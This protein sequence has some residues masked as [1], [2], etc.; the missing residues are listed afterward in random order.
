MNIVLGRSG[1][2]VALLA[3]VVGAVSLGWGLW[4]K[5]KEVLRSARIYA[6]LGLGG[7]LLAVAAMEHALF[8]H[9]FSVAYVADN[10]SVQT[11]LLYDFTGLWSALQGSLL[12][13][14]TMLSGYAMAMIAWLRSRL[15]DP[16]GAWAS[17][18]MFALSG[19]FFF[20]LATQ[21]N[22]FVHLTHPPAN[23]AGPDPLLQDRA[24]VAVHPPL[25][26]LGFVGFSV[27]FALVAGSLITGRSADPLYRSARTWAMAALL[28]L[29]A[30]IVAGEWWAYQVL[31]WGGFWGWDPVE[32]AALLPWLVGCAYV[33]SSLAQERRGLLRVW[34]ISLLA[35]AFCLT[36]LAT[37]LTRSGVLVSVHAFSN[38]NLGGFLIGAFL[39]VAVGSAVLVAWRSDLLASSL[40]IETLASK[41]G[42]FLLNNLAFGAAAAIVLLGTL[43]PLFY[44]AVFGQQI[45]VGAPY[46]DSTLEPVGVVLLFLMAA[47][48]AFGWRDSSLA[49]VLGRLRWP[50]WA[51]AATVVGLVVAGVRPWMAVAAFGLGAF[52]GVSA[53]RGL[54][55]ALRVGVRSRRWSSFARSGGGMLAH[56]G[57]A[58][59][60]V[61]V[62]AS[63]AYAKRAQFLL[64]PRHPVHFGGHELEY[65]GPATSVTPGVSSVEAKVEVDGR[66]VLR[67]AL[68]TFGSSTVAVSSPAIDSGAEDDVYLTLIG[69]ATNSSSPVT[70][71]VVV[72]PLVRWVWTGG[73]ILTAGLALAISGRRRHARA[74]ARSEFARSGGL[75]VLET[76]GLGE[77]S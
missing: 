21:A 14:A 57:I 10:N 73:G 23:G 74:T 44:Q 48:P 8:S 36:L 19:F 11:P 4:A 9:D 51:A 77:R 30:G 52:V 6:A 45:A 27:P 34:N 72:Q 46:F 54:S 15:S 76:A 17:L 47:A 28:F 13:W 55:D 5:R 7:A 41:E 69:A 61:A 3:Y 66:R 25:L 64:Y 39:V 56:L 37:F 65:L 49:A 42:A 75:A 20:L 60:A 24:L 43:F 63:G 58:V 38:S 67:P 2:L 68:S 35:A 59:M 29:S 31:G 50:A 1:I 62:V 22:P 71:G 32:N 70:V 26:Y 40:S 33:H 16:A 12:L 18:I 53:L